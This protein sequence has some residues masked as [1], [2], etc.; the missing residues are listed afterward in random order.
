MTVEGAA[1]VA[2]GQMPNPYGESHQLR[3]PPRSL[4]SLRSSVASGR[5]GCPVTP[6]VSGSGL[7]PASPAMVRKVAPSRRIFFACAPTMFSTRSFSSLW[8]LP[9][10]IWLRSSATAPATTSGLAQV[11]TRRVDHHAASQGWTQARNRQVHRHDA[12][13]RLQRTRPP[14]RQGPP[15]QHQAGN[16]RRLRPEIAAKDLQGAFAGHAEPASKRIGAITG[17]QNKDPVGENR[18][19][20]R[21]AFGGAAL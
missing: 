11:R 13:R 18:I 4:I 10:H 9:F 7:L 3:N 20:R 8:P 2:N 16:V 14:G 5:P 12:A 1:V 6:F 21:H 19:L 15:R 17:G